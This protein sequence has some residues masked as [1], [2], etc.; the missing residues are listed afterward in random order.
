[1]V[2]LLSSQSCCVSLF[3]ISLHRE[4]SLPRWGLYLEAELLDKRAPHK[5]ENMQAPEMLSG[6]KSDVQLHV[7]G[8]K[9][10]QEVE[11]N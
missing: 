4:E 8:T 10:S 1:M 2:P 9:C 3:V 5:G 7:Q 11:E 6:L